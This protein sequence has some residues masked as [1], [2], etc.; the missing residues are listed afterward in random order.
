M[1]YVFHTFMYIATGKPPIAPKL[2]AKL[3]LGIP[4]LPI[5]Q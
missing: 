3:P 2:I 1:V 4:H 5:M